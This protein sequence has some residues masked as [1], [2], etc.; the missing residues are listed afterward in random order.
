MT[1]ILEKLK[2]LRNLG[3][4]SEYS[5]TSLLAILRNNPQKPL[6]VWGSYAF[7]IGTVKIIGSGRSAVIIYTLVT[8]PRGNLSRPIRLSAYQSPDPDFTESRRREMKAIIRDSEVL[9]NKL[10]RIPNLKRLI[11]TPRD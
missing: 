1:K 8:A 5:R 9:S 7:R 6:G 4:D 10:D 11:Y 2:E 3:P